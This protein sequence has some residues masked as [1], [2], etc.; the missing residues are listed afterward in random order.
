MAIWPSLKFGARAMALKLAAR[1]PRAEIERIQQRRLA[2]LVRHARTHSAYHRER[3]SA[4]RGG[5]LRLADLPTSTKAELMENFDRAVTVDDVR[6]DEVEEF[7]ADEGNLGKHFRGK[8]VLSHTSGSQ[9]QPL[10]IVQTMADLELLFALQASRGN[11]QRLGIWQVFRRMSSPARLAA[12]TLK[13]GFYPSGIA[14]EYMPVGARRFIRTLQLSLTDDDIV[15]RLQEY[16]PTHVTAYASVLHE[17]AR[18]TEQGRLSLRPELQQIISISE[19]LMPKARA[20]YEKVFGAPILD[21]YAMGE[22]LYLSNGCPQ[23]GGMHVNA[24]WA[25]LEVVDEANRPV[26]DGQNGAKVLLTNL[27]NLVQP[28]I[29]YEVGDIVTMATHRCGCGNNL[30]LIE[31]VEGRDSDMFWIR[32][33]EDVR[34]MP[35]ALFD[36]ALAN[37]LEVREYQ[38]IHEDNGRVR[39]RIEPLPGVQF[40]RDRA[41]REIE[42]QL[43]AFGL[44][45]HVRVEVEVVDRLTPELG[46][47]FKRFVSKVRA[48]K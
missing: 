23:T 12:V 3:L 21:D 20:H 11:P 39:V 48:P 10:L 1:R 13:R 45:H 6:R 4:V 38:V 33:A 17:L 5:V 22:C 26:P 42:Q 8:Y 29:R 18:Q 41:T 14:F 19:R 28:F 27:S 7:F 15:E 30:P 44:N 32:T 2:R 46:S 35:P 47:K 16:R 25:I 34:P 24:D 31:R 36:L 9:G 43:D 40:D 37:V